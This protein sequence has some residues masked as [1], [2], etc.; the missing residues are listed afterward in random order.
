MQGRVTRSPGSLHKEFHKGEIG[1]NSGY[2]TKCFSH[3]LFITQGFHSLTSLHWSPAHGHAWHDIYKSPWQAAAAHQTICVQGE[4]N[5]STFQGKQERDIVSINSLIQPPTTH[6][7]TH[8]RTHIHT[9]SCV[10]IELPDRKRDILQVSPI[11][12]IPGA[13]VVY[14]AHPA[15]TIMQMSR[16]YFWKHS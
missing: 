11:I 13:R 5:C 3:D 7:R 10:H 2:I 12:T 15:N 14:Q 4:E 8:I 16:F 6:T 9:H 1:S